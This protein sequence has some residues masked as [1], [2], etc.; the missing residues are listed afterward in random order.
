VH[1]IAC[2]RVIVSALETSKE[3]AWAR[4]GLL[5]HRKKSYE[6]ITVESM[7]LEILFRQSLN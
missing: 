6:P 7:Y 2:A 5:R 1:V 3:A 4:F